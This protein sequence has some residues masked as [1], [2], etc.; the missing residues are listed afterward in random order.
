MWFLGMGEYNH[1]A[2]NDTREDF[3]S[4]GFYLIVIINEDCRLQ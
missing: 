4:D 1:L 3:E 2:F